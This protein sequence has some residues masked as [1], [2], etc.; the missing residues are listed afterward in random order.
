MDYTNCGGTDIA[1]KK[2]LIKSL[3]RKQLYRLEDFALNSDVG[4]NLISWIYRSALYSYI[5]EK[6]ND[7]QNLKLLEEIKKHPVPKHIA[8]I[9]D[10]NRRF[11]QTI[12]LSLDSGHFFGKDKV[13]DVLGWCMELGIK[14]LTLYAFS[15]ENFHRSAKE[16]ERL[17][18]L[19]RNELKNAIQDPRLQEH[20]V[21]VK[22]IGHLESLPNDVQ[23]A[24]NYIM[25]QTKQNKRYNLTIALA[26]GGREELINAI[27]NISNDVKN[28][29]LSIDDIN[30]E[31]VS[32]YL[33]TSDLP[34]PDLILRTSGEERI[35]NF[36]LWQI[37]YSEF[38]FLDVYW[39]AMTKRDFLHAIK[40]Y[41]LR[42]RRYGK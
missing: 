28:N 14:N 2:S 10:G 24:A 21:K 40:T 3:A 19:C 42:K 37:A 8:I 30:E 17:M 18:N 15:T 5:R 12:G 31:K 1:T 36:L 23:D 13:K 33:Y 29:V 38:Y 35:S 26:Y 11:A 20:Q 34:D 32:S 16:I 27:Q 25:D 9:M 7:F 22:V 4:R 6:L 39:P 41:Q